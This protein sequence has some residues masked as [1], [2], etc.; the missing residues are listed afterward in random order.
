M[1]RST[2]RVAGRCDD[3]VGHDASIIDGT[4]NSR[5]RLKSTKRQCP[6]SPFKVMRTEPSVIFWMYGAQ[7]QPVTRIAFPIFNNRAIGYRR[8]QDS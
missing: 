3:Q 7:S 5:A 2:L 1:T 6:P 8:D 4:V